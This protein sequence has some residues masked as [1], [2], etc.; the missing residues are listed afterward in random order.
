MVALVDLG[1]LRR[2]SV[3]HPLADEPVPQVSALYGTSGD[4]RTAA[5]I[6]GASSMHPGGC[7]FAFAD[8]SVRFLKDTINTWA[9]DSTTGLPVGVTFDPAG[10][11]KVRPGH[12]VGRL[13]GPLDPPPVTR[14]SAPPTTSE[15]SPLASP[16]RGTRA[17]GSGFGRPCARQCEGHADRGRTRLRLPPQRSG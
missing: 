15:R 14:C 11:Y 1:Q 16:G 17:V 3:L 7:N 13:P 5:Y 8:G 2:H 9:Y 12:E 10:P 4:A 6:S